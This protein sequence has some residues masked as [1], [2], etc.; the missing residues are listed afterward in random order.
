ME[1]FNIINIYIIYCYDVI[2]SSYYYRSLTSITKVGNKLI[3]CKQ[4]MQNKGQPRRS[5]SIDFYC[6]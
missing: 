2:L 6:V 5:T 4:I 1:T 3:A